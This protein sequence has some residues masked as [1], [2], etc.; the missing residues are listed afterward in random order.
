MDT[1][2]NA[3]VKSE[4]I[5]VGVSGVVPAN[6]E[7]SKDEASDFKCPK[8]ECCVELPDKMP[9]SQEEFAAYDAKEPKVKFLVG[10][11][12]VFVLLLIIIIV[13]VTLSSTSS[14]FLS[15]KI[16]VNSILNPPY[17]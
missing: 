7:V 11:I 10:G 8:L 1:S 15:L 2:T 12:C 13:R 3:G 5:K 16:P 17:H 9:T 6:I 4:E 14:C